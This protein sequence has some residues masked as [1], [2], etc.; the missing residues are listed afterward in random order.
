MLARR[1]G[2]VW[3]IAGINGSDEV[4]SYHIPSLGAVT[5]RGKFRRTR[6]EDPPEGRGFFIEEDTAFNTTEVSEFKMQPRGGGLW[7]LQPLSFVH[8]LR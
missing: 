5:G 6:I 4:L 2:P 1:R 3:Y 8:N 7:L